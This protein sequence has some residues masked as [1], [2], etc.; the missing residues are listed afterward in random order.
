M[1]SI[2]DK[3]IDVLSLILT[4]IIFSAVGAL[5]VGVTIK[6]LELLGLMI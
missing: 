4:A 1:K 6:L 3:I 5:I 2:K